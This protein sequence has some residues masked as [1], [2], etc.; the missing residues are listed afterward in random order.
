MSFDFLQATAC[1]CK[2]NVVSSQG[3]A[4]RSL[5]RKALG[6]ACVNVGKMVARNVCVFLTPAMFRS[7]CA[8]QGVRVRGCPIRHFVKSFLSILLSGPKLNLS[9]EWCCQIRSR[10][11]VWVCWDVWTKV[12]DRQ[13]VPGATV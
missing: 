9:V 2:H 8:K 5:A 4:L 13:D 11:S 7:G 1:S 3:D 10:T 6:S 12:C